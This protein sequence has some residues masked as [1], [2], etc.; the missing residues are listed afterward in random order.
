VALAF[1]DVASAAPEAAEGTTIRVRSEAAFAAAV[2]RLRQTGGTIVLLPHRYARLVV[3]P[4]S[5]RPLR[6]VGTRGARVGL[7]R[8]EGTQRVSLGRVAVAPVGGDA[9]I[10]VWRSRHVT[11][12][13][14][15]VTAHRTRHSASILVPDSRHVTIRDS[16]FT[17][18]GDHDPEFVNC[19]TLYRWSHDVAIERNHFR[20]CFGCDFVNGRFG[21][22]L[23]IR[24]NRFERA[25]PCRMGRHRCGHNDLVQ[26]FGGRRLLVTRNHFGVYREGGA[27]LYLTNAVDYATVVNNIFVGSDRRVPGYR[28]RMGIVVGSRLSQRMPLYARIVN[29]TILTGQRRR[30]GYAGSIR[31]SSR[32]GSV[33]RW[34][35]P[36]VANNVI[37]LL[38]TA[39]R[40]CGLTHRFVANV[41]VRGRGCSLDDVVVGPL[42]L[43]RRNRPVSTSPVIDVANRHFAPPRDAAGRPRGEFPDI[44]AYEYRPA[45]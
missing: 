19:V 25:L 34:Q 23:V 32:Y 14:L 6:I 28:A 41:V 11:L 9:R 16:T 12:H 22:D 44:G 7:V 13:D 10:E 4:R 15:A 38:E 29:N 24:D 18:C 45:R 33:P 39:G 42:F 40:V 26:L 27:Q 21:S 43:D 3:G 31:M 35:R 36:V 1:A 30:D 17:H 2:T 20:D 5:W 37:G 8:L